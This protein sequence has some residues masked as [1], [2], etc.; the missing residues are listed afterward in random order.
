MEP[1]PLGAASKAESSDSFAFGN[2]AGV[3]G[4]K[5]SKRAAVG[6][7]GAAIPVAQSC[8]TSTSSGALV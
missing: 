1:P 7:G 3:S 5:P 4:E 2:R 6:A 8:H